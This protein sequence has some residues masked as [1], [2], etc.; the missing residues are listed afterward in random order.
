MPTAEQ[1]KQFIVGVVL[2]PLAGALSTWLYTSVHLLS[3]FHIT[4]GQVAKTITELGVFGIT[5]LLGFLVSHHI[6]SGHYTPA[7]KAKV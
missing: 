4:Q 3:I 2:P 5:S 7:A 1:L 6:L